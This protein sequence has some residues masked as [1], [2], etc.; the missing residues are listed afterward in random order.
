MNTAKATAAPVQVKIGGKNMLLSPLRDV[1]WGEYEEWMRQRYLDLYRAE[2]QKEEPALRTELMK[3][4]YDQASLLSLTHPRA[5]ELMMSLD[6][7][8]QLTWMGLRIRQPEVT[9]E[10]TYKA[11]L[12]EKTYELLFAKFDD[13]NLVPKAKAAKRAATKRAQAKRR[14]KSSIARKSTTGS[15]TGTSGVRKS[16]AK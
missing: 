1:D 4:A 12:D 11:M 13:I 15:R 9:Y 6:G 5:V 10:Q 2:T 7:A 8:T 14:T 3:H 16:S